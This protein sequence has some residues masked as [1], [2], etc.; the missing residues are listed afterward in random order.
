MQTEPA[1]TLAALEAAFTEADEDLRRDLSAIHVRLVRDCPSDLDLTL[2]VAVHGAG[3]EHSP[4]VLR[5]IV[6]G[7]HH[8]AA[9]DDFER[10]GVVRAGSLLALFEPAVLDLLGDL[11]LPV[12]VNP[13]WP[14]EVSLQPFSN[15]LGHP[16][17]PEEC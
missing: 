2:E 11:G 4:P 16:L 9:C 5:E 15:D 13:G 14:T 8:R 3:G 17:D 6:Q 7:P 1:V 10:C 12:S